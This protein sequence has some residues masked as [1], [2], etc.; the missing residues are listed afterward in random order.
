MHVFFDKFEENTMLCPNCGSNYL[1]HMCV[2]VFD[3]EEDDMNGVYT[4]VSNHKI[5]SKRGPLKGNP[6]RR[7]DGIK[8]NF[9][10]EDCDAEPILTI[11][12]HKGQTLVEWL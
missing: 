5:E 3:R 8:I 7:R 9:V 11:A 1:H 4:C 12:Q 2:E 10:C 6:S